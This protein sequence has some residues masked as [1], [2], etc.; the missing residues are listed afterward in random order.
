MALILALVTS[1]LIITWVLVYTLAIYKNDE[2]Y[3]GEGKRTDDNG[4]EE[5][6]Y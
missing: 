1:V 5:T 2:V 3:L 6:H 4:R